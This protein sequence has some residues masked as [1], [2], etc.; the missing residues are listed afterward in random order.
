MLGFKHMNKN[1]MYWKLFICS[2]LNKPK[3]NKNHQNP[4]CSVWLANI[5]PNWNVLCK[6]VD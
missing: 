6:W 4:I 1:L 2:K 3:K 5:E